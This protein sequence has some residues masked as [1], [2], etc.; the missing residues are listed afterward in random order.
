[1]I[2][3]T[4]TLFQQY[5]TYVL[6]ISLFL[7]SCGSLN[8][9][10]IPIQ[11]AKTSSTKT[12]TQEIISQTSIHPLFGQVL[13]AEGGNAVT[14]Y[15]YKGELQASIEVLDEKDK[16]Y[17]GLSVSIEKEADLRSL[18]HLPK[19][20]QQNRIHI[21]KNSTGK[22]VK[23]IIY[24][25]SGL[26]GGMEVKKDE[27]QRD[28]CITPVET[29]GNVN[30]TR[31]G[32]NLEA[33]F[34]ETLLSQLPEGCRLGAAYDD[35]DC[36]FDALAQWINI[37]NH[38]DV[39]NVK[40]LRTLCHNFYE[41]NKDLVDSWNQADYGGIDQG[42]DEYYMVQYTSEECE[43]DFYG[44][45]PI[46][47]RSSVEGQILCKKLGLESILSIEVLKDP[48]TGNPVISYHLTTQSGYRSS[49]DQKE[50]K[51]LLQAGDIPTIINVQDK[52]HFVPLLK[53]Q[54]NRIHTQLAQVA[55]QQLYQDKVHFE[56]GNN[57]TRNKGKEKDWDVDEDRKQDK[58]ETH[59][60]NTS[61]PP[62]QQI[63]EKNNLEEE[64][65]LEKEI[66]TLKNEL[67]NNL[68]NIYNP[69]FT[70]RLK[71]VLSIALKNN[72]TEILC[73]QIFENSPIDLI[74]YFLYLA[75]EEG[76]EC[77][78]NI[79]MYLQLNTHIRIEMYLYSMLYNIVQYKDNLYKEEFLNTWVWYLEIYDSKALIDIQTFL[80]TK[81]E[82]LRSKSKENLHK[83][84][85]LKGQPKV[86]SKIY[87][88]LPTSKE[89]IES[90]EKD[91]E[92][93]NTMVGILQSLLKKLEDT[94]I[95][96]LLTSAVPLGKS[97]PIKDIRE[98][99]TF[100]SARL[101]DLE[102]YSDSESDSEDEEVPYYCIFNIT[103]HRFDLMI[104]DRWKRL[105]FQG[106]YSTPI[107]NYVTNRKQILLKGDASK[108]YEEL[109][110]SSAKHTDSVTILCV[111]LR[112]L[113]GHIKKFVFTNQ[114][115]FSKDEL[116]YKLDIMRYIMQA[117]H[118]KGYHVIMTEWGHAETALVQFLLVRPNHYTHI[119]AMDCDRKHCN[120][121]KK[122]L[123]NFTDEI[124]ILRKISSTGEEENV[125]K[126]ASTWRT[127]RI[128]MR[129]KHTKYIPHIMGFSSPPFIEE[130]KLQKGYYQ[131]QKNICWSNYKV[132][133]GSPKQSLSHKRKMEEEELPEKEEVHLDSSTSTLDDNTMEY[134]AQHSSLNNPK[135]KKLKNDG[136]DID[137]EDL[138][139]SDTDTMES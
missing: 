42:G 33:H 4:Y 113:D 23:V 118:K 126:Y 58:E 134:E 52:Q 13:T 72:F 91:I 48:E 79:F 102:E 47:G 133:F 31:E 15:E 107:E 136:N 130:Q 116:T 5:I 62:E 99:Y 128:L 69:E 53:G 2:K 9:P 54:Q 76:E 1:M 64:K 125:N 57:L 25:N 50:G 19:N 112:Q 132:M 56:G 104:D 108:I 10:I 138:K 75:H 26:I 121:C 65:E 66:D 61:L 21:Q 39:N 109:R 117:S 14:F 83:I 30:K 67:K 63:A 24:K 60:V 100:S 97:S 59:H 17:N 3:R 37:I 123:V 94:I 7:Q 32:L 129:K 78:Q 93:N 12:L 34:Q 38:T 28:H 84:N 137:K 81:A 96:K 95:D 92:C 11:K 41:N 43:R 103:K 68:K 44:R 88:M 22:P 120:S 114:P 71:R 90:L 119:V 70:N 8:N 106:I 77:L 29:Q 6:L 18:S 98:E 131:R 124:K 86:R 87:P 35:G 101:A 115:S 89:E 55:T 80:E 20:I 49:I 51:G 73:C 36:F 16:V 40:Y 127:P 45:P 110:K 46:W 139:P 85:R 111:A 82:E 74:S 135:E 105:I 27:E 122:L